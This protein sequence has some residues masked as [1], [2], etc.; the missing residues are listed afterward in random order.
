MAK[1][2][3]STV[4]KQH[5]GSAVSF[6]FGMVFG[7]VIAFGVAMY[8]SKAQL[9]FSGAKTQAAVAN[10]SPGPNK[11]PPDPNNALYKRAGNQAKATESKSDTSLEADPIAAIA[12]N[13]GNQPVARTVYYL[14]LGSFRNREDAEQLRARLAFVG[15]ESDVVVG[16][17]NGSVVNRVRVGPFTSANEAY[18]ARIPLTK[19]GFEASV[20]K[21]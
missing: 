20:V 7:L 4:A 2:K 15:T 11:A 1:A 10:V 5:G 12:Q 8:V 19:S 6:I 21:E 13:E 14:Q 9:P 3:S 18:L 17:V 16:D